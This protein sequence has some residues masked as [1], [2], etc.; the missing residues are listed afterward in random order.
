MDSNSVKFLKL[1]LHFLP[2]QCQSVIRSTTLVQTDISISNITAGTNIHGTQK[3]NL[4][5]VV[6]SS[7]ENFFKKEG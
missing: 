5:L 4:D 3:M 1:Q 2:R 6:A 7:I